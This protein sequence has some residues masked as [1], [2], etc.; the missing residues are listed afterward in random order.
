MRA[1]R[2]LARGTL[3][4]L[5]TL[6]LLA[7]L[8][9][10]APGRVT[11]LPGATM[12]D[13]AILC[14]DPAP[15][16]QCVGDPV[17]LPF[18]GGLSGAVGDVVRL[19]VTAGATAQGGDGPQA[20]FF[21]L[22]S[23]ALTVF[24]GQTPVLRTATG[25]ETPWHWNRPAY[26]R[27]PEPLQA[28]EAPVD[29]VLRSAPWF[30]V[31]LMPFHAGPDA[32]LRDA[33]LWRATLTRDVARFGLLLALLCTVG[34]T[35]LAVTRRGD[36]VYRWAAIA[37]AAATV[38]SLHYASTR[39]PLPA[40]LWQALWT[41]SV[42]ILIAALHRFIRRFLRRRPDGFETATLAFALG[43]VPV[44]FVMA[45]AWPQWLLAASALVHAVALVITIYLLS[46]FLRDRRFTTPGRFATLYVAMSVTAALALHDALYFYLRPPPVAM[47]LGQFMPMVFMFV[48]GW[49]VL[50]Q[51]V[52]A[53]GR[54][55]ALA[56]KLRE[57]VILRSQTLRRTA[58]ALKA[59]ER[60]MLLTAERQRIMMDLHDG[61][62]G[63]LVN[64]LAGL[65]HSDNA[66][67]HLRDLLEEAQTDMGLI[68]DSLYNPGDVAGLLAMM[69]A[70]L[71]PM[72][73]RQGLRFDWQV[74][75]E[76]QMP[77]PGPSSNIDLLRI[78]QEF[79]TNTSKHAQASC[80]TVQTG[81]RHLCL[82]DDGRGLDMEAPARRGHGL[83]S[84]RRRA[85]R[86]GATL[87]L[88]GGEG[89]TTLRLDWP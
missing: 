56:A 85:A 55:E 84:M 42:P 30:E 61:V 8:V 69:R 86:I 50:M 25:A 11:P 74:E 66:D 19:R 17:P 21:P 36:K 70:R 44:M 53:L 57:R 43:S 33:Y 51:L 54:Q 68:I 18:F 29:L 87:T 88:T 31:S 1:G 12:I 6:T 27:V 38:L 3:S 32:A 37:G 13:R 9:W 75:D 77:D 45:L 2:G 89:G 39:P 72:L 41:V 14:S 48:T 7:A 35:G 5:L 80:I 15:Q 20:M 46:I 26:V 60:E 65:R 24:V 73:E 10:L 76:P 4:V 47:Q 28:G 49:L 34:M 79:V 58:D 81:R 59:R 63:H 64:A 82:T 78:V 83:A 22:F 52:T 67:P 16:A 23:D 71:E 62:G 40:P